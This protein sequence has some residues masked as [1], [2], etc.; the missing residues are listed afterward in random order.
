MNFAFGEIATAGKSGRSTVY[1]N[2]GLGAAT[3]RGVDQ[4]EPPSVEY[5]TSACSWLMA[6]ARSGPAS[7]HAR[8]SVSD[9]SPE[10]PFGAPF[11][12]SRLGQLFVRAP[13][14][15]SNLRDSPS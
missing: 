5:L 10:C 9:G 13:R 3:F 11:A 4:V 2:G 8:T 6:F 12:T 7:A 14:T 1:G 15:P